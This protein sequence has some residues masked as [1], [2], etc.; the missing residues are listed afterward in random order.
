MGDAGASADFPAWNSQTSGRAGPPPSFAGSTKVGF[1]DTN[2]LPC[3]MVANGDGNKQIWLTEVGAP[4]GTS[5]RAVTE[6]KQAQTI[7]V[8]LKFARANSYIGAIYPYSMFDTGTNLADP[9]DNFGLLHTNFTTKLA[10]GIWLL[11]QDDLETLLNT[12]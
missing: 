10:W 12:L 9:E 11:A 8:L 3:P 4:T 2:N 1:A 6:K 5:S 7:A